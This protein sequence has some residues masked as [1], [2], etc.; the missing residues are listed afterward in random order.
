MIGSVVS[1]AAL[2]GASGTAAGVLGA[3]A[4]G[5]YLESRLYGISAVEPLTLAMVLSLVLATVGLAAYVP[6]RRAARVN[7]TMLLR[8]E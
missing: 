1:R 5:L 3:V 8:H 2:L 7:P 6:A 4:V